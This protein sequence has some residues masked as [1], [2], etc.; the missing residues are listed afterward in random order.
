MGQSDWL[1]SENVKDHFMN[2]KNLLVDESA[3]KADGRGMVGNI[4]CGDQM[5]LMIKVDKD[6]QIITDCK[7]KT[8]GCASAIA[9]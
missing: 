2:P 1:Y 8:Y 4:K 9:S 3:F 6:K 7:W 5:L